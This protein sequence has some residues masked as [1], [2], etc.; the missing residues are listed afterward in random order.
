MRGVPGGTCGYA[1]VLCCRCQ[2]RRIIDSSLNEV[3]TLVTKHMRRKVSHL[4]HTSK[5]NGQTALIQLSRQC[6]VQVRSVCFVHSFSGVTV[7]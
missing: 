3:T 1:F 5:D 6:L 4:D 7:V 2:T